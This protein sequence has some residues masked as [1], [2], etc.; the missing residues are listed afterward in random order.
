MIIIGTIITI[1]NT[2]ISVRKRCLRAQQGSRIGRDDRTALLQMSQ[3]TSKK[4]LSLLMDDLFNIIHLFPNVT[5]LLIC[6]V[7]FKSSIGRKMTE[8]AETSFWLC[9]R[10]LNWLHWFVHERSAYRPIVFCFFFKAKWVSFFCD[11][12]CVSFFLSDSEAYF[13]DW[14][15]KWVGKTFL[16]WIPFM[17]SQ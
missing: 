10:C 14:Q 4:K 9:A 2:L 15:F 12:M 6:T 13:K 7:R 11:R 8:S 17:I 3:H 5:P 1:P 16:N